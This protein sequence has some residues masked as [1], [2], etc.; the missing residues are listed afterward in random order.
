MPPTLLLNIQNLA[1]LYD[2]FD[3]ALFALGNILEQIDRTLGTFLDQHLTELAAVTATLRPVADAE[4]RLAALLEPIFGADVFC[5]SLAVRSANASEDLA[6]RSFAGVYHSQ[7]DQQGAENVLSAI[8]SV[9]GSAFQKAALVEQLS[10]GELAKSDAMHVMIQEMI[11]PEFS[12]VAFSIDPVN[13]RNHIVVELV[14]GLGEKLVS[15][16]AVSQRFTICR[17][18]GNIAVGSGPPAPEIG[19]LEEIRD[20]IY[21]LEES[22]DSLVDIEWAWTEGALW[23]LQARNI[24]ALQDLTQQ[25]S[26]DPVFV[27]VDLYGESIMEVQEIATIPVFASYFRNKR[28]PLH[29]IALALGLACSAAKLIYVNRTGLV[30]NQVRIQKSFSSQQVVLDFND[31][32]RQVIMPTNLLV[33]SLCDLMPEPSRLYTIVIRDFIQG[34]LGLITQADAQGNVFGEASAEG[35]L[36][37]N[38]GTARTYRL[39]LDESNGMD[40]LGDLTAAQKNMLICVSREAR[41]KIGPIQIEWVLEN[42]NLYALDFSP[43]NNTNVFDQHS[44]ESILS[45]GFHQAF[46]FILDADEMLEHLS[47]APAVSLTEVPE[48]N[49]LGEIFQSI[50]KTL[51]GYDTKPIIVTQRP[52][53]VLAALL[54]Y[55]GGF[56]FEAGS[57]LCHLA[58]L[59]REHR[60]PAIQGSEIYSRARQEEFVTLAANES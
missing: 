60:I 8:L 6:S 51:E 40:A 17:E 3:D 31:K 44:S 1:A 4:T 10:T 25:Y 46:S 2:G 58:I 19:I 50:V 45:Q 34:T 48:A 47:I 22:M 52:Y 35:L 57:A 21:R 39:R 59:L 33:H 37:I 14:D 5:R 28:K 13:A 41:E 38:R 53:A 11:Y 32:F 56:I 42:G 18:T 26:Q 36:A 29:D 7:L 49:D 20:L 23:G 30:A 54:P 27:S 43:V 9:W 16:S 24:T 15:G 12:G 55:V